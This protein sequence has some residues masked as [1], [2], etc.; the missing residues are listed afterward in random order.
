MIITILQAGIKKMLFMKKKCCCIAT[1]KI[2]SIDLWGHVLR[3]VSADKENESWWLKAN[4]KERFGCGAFSN[5]IM[6]SCLIAISTSE[7]CSKVKVSTSWISF[8]VFSQRELN[9][10]WVIILTCRHFSFIANFLMISADVWCNIFTS[11]YVSSGEVRL[12]IS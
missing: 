9:T 1:H 3:S 8:H 12:K 7:W 10:R 2:A 5:I 11:N 6:S 4:G